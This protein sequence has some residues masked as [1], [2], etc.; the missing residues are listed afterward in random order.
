[1][2]HVLACPYD[3]APWPSNPVVRQDALAFAHERFREGRLHGECRFE[4]S[5]ET[6]LLVASGDRD[7]DEP[8]RFVARE[9]QPVIPGS[10]LKGM[11]RAVFEA[12]TPSC[13]P[14]LSFRYATKVM[15]MKA[16]PLANQRRDLKACS[17]WTALCPACVL[18]GMVARKSVFKGRVRITDAVLVDNQTKYRMGIAIPVQ[19]VP[20]PKERDHRSRFPNYFPAG[21]MAG[22]KFYH[23]WSDPPK[24]APRP[25]KHDGRSHKE[26]AAEPLEAGHRFQFR[27]Q[28]QDL[29]PQEL[30]CLLLA[31]TLK[32]DW[33]HKLGAAK[34][35]GWGSCRVKLTGWRTWTPAKRY[36]SWAASE[37]WETDIAKLAAQR[38]AL[39]KQSLTSDVK[40]AFDAMQ[41]LLDWVGRP[42]VRY[43]FPPY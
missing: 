33:A 25:K 32:P 2:S 1:M 4:L 34:A 43:G 11:V 7:E 18:F 42:N 12:I 10:S 16:E 21:R 40:A 28:Y 31:I 27:V 20:R 15:P 13:I 9:G 26:N 38:D 29:E 22:R 37:A 41:P 14:I 8:K 5:N 6:L 35:F 36:R 24:T 17:D 39:L 23:H 3:F 19:G 30:A